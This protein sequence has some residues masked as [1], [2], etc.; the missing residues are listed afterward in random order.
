VIKKSQLNRP[1]AIVK[2][3]AP[4]APLRFSF[5]L[6]DETDQEMCPA[7]FSNGYTRTLMQRLRALFGWTVRDFTSRQESTI[8]NHQH[9]WTESSRPDG[10]SHLNAHYRAYPGWQFSL[11][12]NEHG[13]VHGII[14][15]DTFYVIWLDKDH[16]LYP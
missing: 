14:I 1:S 15:D 3:P 6:F 10:F 2:Q 7:I 9:D 16:A 13:R 5:K 11:T 12:A 8:R 4:D